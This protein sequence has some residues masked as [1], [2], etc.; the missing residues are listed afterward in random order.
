MG[1]KS[2]SGKDKDSIK[3][4]GYLSSVLPF[5]PPGA[6]VKELEANLREQPS[7]MEQV[8]IELANQSVSSE[9]QR[10]IVEIGALKIMHLI[11]VSTKDRSDIQLYLL[12][13]Y[14]NLA[15][16][17]GNNADFL[18]DRSCF[19]NLV[20]ALS[21]G[22]SDLQRKAARAITNLA[23]HEENKH[24]FDDLGA[25]GGLLALARHPLEECR[26]EAIAA[27]GNLAVN[28]ELERKIAKQGGIEAV[29]DCVTSSNSTLR[30]HARRALQNL[31]TQQEN[32]E[33][34]YAMLA[35]PSNAEA[36]EGYKTD[37]SDEET[38]SAG[39]SPV[40]IRGQQPLTATVHDHS[41]PQ[42]SPPPPPIRMYGNA[43]AILLV[44]T[45]IG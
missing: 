5:L 1:N 19:Y 45:G 8:A 43:I 2:S 17:P 39:P 9:F 21:S 28:D 42:G 11:T 34:Y 30:S 10:N 16:H 7:R 22:K 20:D 40:T 41:V 38:A 26:T 25:I 36:D 3:A 37:T 4:P 35:A 14:G 33:A 23:V 24:H 12:H 31:C 18:K 32:K 15:L 13:A 6:S 29:Y 44:S 27:L